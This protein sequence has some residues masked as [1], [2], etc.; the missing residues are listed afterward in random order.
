MKKTAAY[1]EPIAFKRSW[2]LFLQFVREIRSARR[3]KPSKS[4]LLNCF[5]EPRCGLQFGSKVPEHCPE[6]Q[7]YKGCEKK[8]HGSVRWIPPI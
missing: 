6:H 2:V 5:K 7:R 8:S 1:I 4:E 3:S